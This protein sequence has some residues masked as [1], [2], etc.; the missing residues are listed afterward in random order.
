M[1][2][3]PQK[4]LFTEIWRQ[5]FVRFLL[6]NQTFSCRTR[7]GA[8]RH[9]YVLK[10]WIEPK[11]KKNIPEEVVDLHDQRL[12]LAAVFCREMP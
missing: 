12:P 5:L 8:H 7:S 9:H 1:K 3:T 4:P 11:I 6:N 10:H 2:R